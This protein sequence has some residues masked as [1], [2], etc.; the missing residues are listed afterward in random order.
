MLYAVEV[1]NALA[2][3]HLIPMNPALMIGLAE[4]THGGIGYLLVEWV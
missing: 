3:F 4:V 2:P 1:E